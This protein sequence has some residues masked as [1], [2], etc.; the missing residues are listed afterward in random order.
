[1]SP[2][3]EGAALAPEQYG[4]VRKQVIFD[5][6]KWDPQVEDTNTIADRP[7]VLTEPAW[8]ELAT[9]A[10]ALCREAMA[11][12]Q[13]LVERPE[14]QRK[15]GIAR[16]L[17]A[18]MDGA[19]DKRSGDVRVMRFDFHYTTA[20]WLISEV[21]S[22]V[23]GGFNEAGGMARVFASL[24]PGTR[25]AG[26]PA[27]RMAQ[28]IARNLGGTGVIALV[29]ATAYTD[30]RQVMV[31]IARAL[32]REGL[33]TVLAA[34][35]ALSWRDGAPVLIS[36]AYAGPVDHL[37]RFFPV[38]WMP[39]LDASTGWRNYLDSDAPASN[40]GRAVLC[41]TK[42]FPLVWRELDTKLPT[43]E[44]LL[45]ESRCPRTVDWLDDAGWVLKP[46]FGRVGDGVGLRECIGLKEWAAIVKGARRY[47]DEWVV[48]RRFNALPTASGLFPCF[49][50]YTVDGEAIGVYG[51]AAPRRLV[52][53]RAMDI[54][55]L[56]EEST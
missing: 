56:V 53:H 9:A 12:E 21:N 49:G 5:C 10:E 6:G 36:D 54:A 32:E 7:I 25:T 35:D 47:P 26:D 3:I 40:P 23:P 51:R 45:P 24:Y 41:Q 14:L 30:D 8:R 15:L 31:F 22:D 16:P 43:W 34:P 1:M 17:R 42:R 44:R 18:A 29:H 13:E 52:D 39:N 11:A 33:T 48:Q 19:D 2:W 28:A 27:A 55:V 50:V 38:E 20:G 4:A 46:A 37:V